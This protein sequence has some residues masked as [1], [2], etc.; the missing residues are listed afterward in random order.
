[1]NYKER[2]A[3]EYKKMKKQL[4]RALTQEEVDLCFQIADA[5]EKRESE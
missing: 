1:M 4:G 5:Y 3:E 2:V